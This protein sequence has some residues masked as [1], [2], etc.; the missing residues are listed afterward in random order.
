MQLQHDFILRSLQPFLSVPQ[1]T[2]LTT[3]NKHIAHLCSRLPIDDWL[4]LHKF[5]D[6]FIWPHIRKHKFFIDDNELYVEIPCMK[7]PCAMGFVQWGEYQYQDGFCKQSMP[8][9]VEIQSVQ[10]LSLEAWGMSSDEIVP[11]SSNVTIG[12]T[13]FPVCVRSV[14]RFACGYA[15]Q[16][17]IGK[18]VLRKFVH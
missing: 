4:I 2:Q 18:D 6:Q 10:F 8:S 5:M 14:R 9:K 15:P 3:V 1:W 12:N 17:I 13:V 16:V 11:H 7:Q